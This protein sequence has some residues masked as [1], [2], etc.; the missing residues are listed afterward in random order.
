MAV[1]YLSPSGKYIVDEVYSF[2][3]FV[4]SRL[5]TF[6]VSGLD[7]SLRTAASK[8]LRFFLVSVRVSALQLFPRLFFQLNDR[9]LCISYY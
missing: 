8:W 3:G 6:L 4:L 5:Q 9:R 2:H 7:I 1:N